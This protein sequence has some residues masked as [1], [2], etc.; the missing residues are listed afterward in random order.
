[1]SALANGELELFSTFFS[2]AP[3][4]RWYLHELGLGAKCKISDPMADAEAAKRN[5]SPFGKMPSL[6]DMEN[7]K[8]IGIF[9]SG[10]V[11][12]Y[13]ADKYTNLDTPAK[14]ANLNQWLF[15]VNASL[16]PLIMRQ[17]PSGK[18]TGTALSQ[19]P[20]PKDIAALEKILGERAWLAGDDFSAADV[21]AGSYLLYVK[22][23]FKDVDMSRLPNTAAYMERCRKRP[24]YAVAWPPADAPALGHCPAAAAADK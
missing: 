5:P 17:D 9:E 24:G 15:F 12:M 19:D 6:C 11:L 3:M 23:L 14:R 16:C 13:L 20:L 8:P 21:A 10:A 7:G 2:R 1:M 22:E 18:V 4:V